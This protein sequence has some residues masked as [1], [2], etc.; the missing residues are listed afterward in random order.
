MQ[1]VSSAAIKKPE[2]KRGISAK[3]I[4]ETLQRVAVG[5]YEC[6][7]LNSAAHKDNFDHAGYK[8]NVVVSPNDSKTYQSTE[9]DR[10]YCTYIGASNWSDLLVRISS[11][12]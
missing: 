8:I 6:H 2:M 9:V 3:S 11:V 12:L 7:T 5:C 10:S 1:V 4:P